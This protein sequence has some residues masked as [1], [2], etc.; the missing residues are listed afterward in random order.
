MLIDFHVHC[1]PDR[2]ADNA[3]CQL[4]ANVHY[5]PATDGTFGDLSACL[6]E[7]GV[8]RAVCLNV[9][10]NAHQQASVNNFAASINNG[11]SIFA[12]GSVHASTPAAEQEL[13]RIADLGLRGIKLH[14]DY[15]GIDLLDRRM[16]PIYDTASELGLLCVFHSGWDPASPDR[17]RVT[18]DG[19]LRLRR[20][21]PR[22]RV[23]LAHL[24][25]LAMWDEVEEKLVGTG[26]LMDTALI[27]GMISPE[28]A[29]RII[30]KNGAENILF[31]S[32]APW[33]SSRATADFLDSLALSATEK[34]RIFYRNAEE[35]LEIC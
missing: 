15:Q 21:F 30:R 22:L 13:Y 10:T 18:P 33:Q 8:G 31:G 3:I 16:F 19:V 11:S 25:G 35:L 29:V 7:W 23:I 34:D 17:T 2:V 9:A 32:D 20:L 6:K 26:V 14:P 27:R 24:G 4:K 5:A 1:F 12:F 28:Q